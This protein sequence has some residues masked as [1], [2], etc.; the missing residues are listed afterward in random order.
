MPFTSSSNTADC[1]RDVGL[2]QRDRAGGVHISLR[3]AALAWFGADLVVFNALSAAGLGLA[4]AHCASFL[5]AIGCFLWVARLAAFPRQRS[6]IGWSGVAGI[7]TSCILALFL[8]GAILAVLVEKWQCPPQVAI[9]PCVV[10]SAVVSYLGCLFFVVSEQPYLRWRMAAAGVIAYALLLR[11]CYIGLPELIPEEAYYWNYAQH[12]DLSYLDHPPMVA[13]LIWL[14]TGLFGDGEFGVRFG[15]FACWLVAAYFC[16]R[17]TSDLFEGQSAIRALMLLSVLPFF[18]GVGVFM[19]PDA[20]VIACW[21]GMLHFLQR[22]LLGGRRLAWWGAGIA[23]GLG[24]LSKYTI[25]LLV[26]AAA[27]FM[28]CD[29]SSRRWLARP[30]PY[31]ALLVAL[32]L[33]MPVLIWNAGHD[34]ASFVFQGTRRLAEQSRFSLHL[35]IGS[36]AILLTPL[37][38]AWAARTLLPSLSDTARAMAHPAHRSRRFTI[39][40]L[41][42]PL[43]VFVAFSITHSIRLNW[44]GPVLL[45]ALPAMAWHLRP[46]PATSWLW[47]WGRKLWV[48]T[49]AGSLIVYGGTLHYLVLGLP[50]IGYPS[51]TPLL[52]WRDL[53]AQLEALEDNFE[54]Q[55]GVE[56]MIVGMDR[57]NLA[58]EAAFYRQAAGARR[59]DP[60]A[61]EDVEETAGRELFG[62][63]CLMYEYW[64]NPGLAE[65][66]TM[67]L[68]GDNDEELASENVQHHFERLGK[69]EQMV[70]TKNGKT[71]GRY[72]YRFA[73]GYRSVL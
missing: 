5:A 69:I 50:G 34:W 22:A 62:R 6:G 27:V 14:S 7:G 51:G 46:R 56:P 37:G 59:K 47:R 70:V 32:L 11:L 45:A 64:S 42:V 23:L 71:A 24:L 43:L 1:V 68:I 19:T 36:L 33:F 52:G 12:L 48:P 16:Y 3:L 2:S 18:F 41:L 17:L 13:W 49:I 65:G 38:L 20:P 57:Y 54:E 67:V 4:A 40:F 10:V 63:S 44:V 66:R 25:A 73:Y 9:V 15:A 21:A 58:S 8:R 53:G 55:T 26:P 72:Y 60:R 29:K 39:I 31:A 35:L 61:R 28:V 30:E